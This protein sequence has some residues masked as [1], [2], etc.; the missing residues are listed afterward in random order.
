LR[1][2]LLASLEVMV[3]FAIGFVL[4]NVLSLIL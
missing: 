3:G 1:R 4:F 2:A